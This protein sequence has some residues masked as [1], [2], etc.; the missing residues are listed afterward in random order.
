MTDRIRVALFD[1]HP[2]MR[3]GILQV[4]RGE[5]DIE[6]IAEGATKDDAVAVAQTNPLDIIFLDVN[7]PGGGIEAARII[8]D[9]C[10]HVRV[11]MLTVSEDEEHVSS[12][13]RAGASG[14]ILK[15]VSGPEFVRTIHAIHDGDDYVSP[16]LAAR[17]LAD[18][19]NQTKDDRSDTNPLS[20]LTAREEQIVRLV[21]EGFSNKEVGENLHLSEK[22]IKHYMTNILQKL[23]VRNRVEAALLIRKQIEDKNES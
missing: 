5:E 18:I 4:L 17:L 22:T 9:S 10:P 7:M 14:Y 20:D 21:A 2:M 1:D 6:I 8:S 16:A 11:V 13:L 3:E 12:A 15:G 23:H 19:K